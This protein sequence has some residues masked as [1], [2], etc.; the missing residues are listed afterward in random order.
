MKAIE[1]L[2]RIGFRKVGHWIIDAKNRIHYEIYDKID[3]D[4]SHLLY[5]FESNSVVKYIGITE[6]TL[7]QR[8]DNYKSGITKKSGSTNSKVYNKI[9]DTISSGFMINIWILKESAKCD[10]FG[11]EISLATGIEKSLIKAFDL[12]E[13]LWN[14]RGTNNNQNTKIVKTAMK[15]N[16]KNEN[17]QTILRLG[18]Y[19]REGWLMFKNEDELYLPIESTHMNIIY[20]SIKIEGC[21]FTRSFK[22]KKINGGYELRK[23]FED[24]FK[25]ENYVKVTI[26]KNNE[27][28]IEKS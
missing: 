17:Y 19:A 15:N 9:H 8:L 5:S 24:D 10:Y 2:K 28:K 18:K 22:N 12:K 1:E 16:L 27:V 14:S 13:N 4:L 11:Y 7:K 6:T 23:I 25:N 20:K 21:R 26:L 3:L